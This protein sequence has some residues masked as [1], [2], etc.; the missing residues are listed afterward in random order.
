MASE[1]ATRTGARVLDEGVERFG[2]APAVRLEGQTLT[3]RELR[4]RA[5]TFA[6]GLGRLGLGPG[7]RLL[8]M[9]PNSLEFVE[10][11]SG[12]ALAGVIEVPVHVEYRGELLRHVVEHSGARWIL[13]EEE[14]VP[15]VEELGLP[16]EG[17]VLAGRREGA[18][19][20]LPELAESDPVPVVY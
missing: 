19:A 4:M 5:G 11:W 17:L 7:D 18:A 20:D 13:L 1:H 16:L 12:C 2:D 3:Y 9:L 8:I 14:F 15:R 6:G 10:A